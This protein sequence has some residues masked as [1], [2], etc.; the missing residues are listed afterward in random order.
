M[1]EGVQQLLLNSSGCFQ[2]HIEEMSTRQALEAGFGEHTLAGK[3]KRFWVSSGL[4][5]TFSLFC[6]FAP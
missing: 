5:T 1:V 6:V 4:L 3:Q 2:R